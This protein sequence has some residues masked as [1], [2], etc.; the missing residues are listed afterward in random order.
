M[1]KN[2]AV[3][4][5]QVYKGTDF[6]TNPMYLNIGEL[7]DSFMTEMPIIEENISV[8]LIS[9]IDTLNNELDLELSYTFGEIINEYSYKELKPYG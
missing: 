7:F 4:F 1:T 3:R 6:Y 5:F 8:I 9:N 2:Q